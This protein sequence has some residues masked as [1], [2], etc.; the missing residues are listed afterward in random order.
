MPALIEALIELGGYYE[1]P[2]D[3]NS[4]RLGPLVGYAGRYDDNGTAK[5]WVGDKYFNFAALEKKPRRSLSFIGE[6]AWKL[7]L[8]DG[9]D[10]TFCGMPEGGK[11]VALELAS[12]TNGSYIYP[13]KKVL[14]LATATSKERAELIFARHQ[15]IP[16]GKVFIVEDVMNNFSTTGTG[17]DLITRA[18]GEVCGIVGLL[19][20]SEN[21]ESIFSHR[22]K[23]YPITSILRM[24][25]DEYKQDDP[26]VADDIKN[27]NIVWKPKDEWDRLQQ[28]MKLAKK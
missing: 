8:D 9:K 20:R 2:K 7:H 19:N 21:H 4:K 6:L 26:A 12:W 25:V 23:D 13:E 15:V 22:G 10:V 11:W 16:G 28:A 3:D 24:K 27:G 1:C 14:E 18:G 17:I 5:Q